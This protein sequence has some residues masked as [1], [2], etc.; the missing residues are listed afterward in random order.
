[1]GSS[2]WVAGIL[3]SMAK[4]VKIFTT[5]ST[6]YRFIQCNDSLQILNTVHMPL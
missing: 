4:V 1:M 5:G 6:G 3:N 2:V